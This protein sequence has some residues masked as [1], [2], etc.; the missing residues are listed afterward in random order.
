MRPALH[1]YLHAVAANMVSAGVRLIPL[2]QT[3][4]QRTLA[5]LAPAITATAERA[6]PP[7]STMSAAPRSAPTS[8]A[9][10]TRRNTRGCSAHDL[11]AVI[12]FLA[13]AGI[14]AAHVAWGFGAR[15]AGRQRATTSFTW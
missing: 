6:P 7:R 4:G 8:P 13:L 1:A 11:L 5:A 9:C 15:L 2:G 14:A 3:D 10:G 12:V